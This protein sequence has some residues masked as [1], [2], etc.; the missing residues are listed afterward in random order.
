[1]YIFNNKV[2]KFFKNNPTLILTEGAV[3][4]V[5][6]RGTLTDTQHALALT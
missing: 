1:M 2:K 5:V 4:A 6:A 3:L